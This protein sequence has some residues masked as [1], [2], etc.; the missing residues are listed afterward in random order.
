VS[1]EGT[2]EGGSPTW[3][4]GIRVFGLF[5]IIRGCGWVVAL[6]VKAPTGP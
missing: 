5:L 4:V 3:G 1:W 6:G 2:W